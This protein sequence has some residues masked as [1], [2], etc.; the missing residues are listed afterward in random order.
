M[1]KKIP[2]AVSVQVKLK[3]V[4]V[5]TQFTGAGIVKE[6][7]QLLEWY[8]HKPWWEREM[9]WY[10]FILPTRGQHAYKR[11]MKD[12]SKFLDPLST[13]TCLFISQHVI[14]CYQLPNMESQQEGFRKNEKATSSKFPNNSFSITNKTEKAMEE[15]RNQWK[16]ELMK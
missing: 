2:A 14:F 9:D 8:N 10:M 5:K 7:G 15:E 16:T 3:F 4:E 13:P 12:S 6:G 1:K 11:L